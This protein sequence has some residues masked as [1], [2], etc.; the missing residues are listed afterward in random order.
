MEK[1]FSIILIALT[2]LLIS[3]CCSV[4]GAYDLGNHLT[5]L[6][7]DHTEDRVIVYCTTKNGCCDAGIPI[8]PSR[9]DSITLYVEKAEYNKL[10]IIVKGVNRED[11]NNF[12][13]IDKNFQV[14]FKLDDGGKLYDTIQNHVIGP[15]NLTEFKDKKQALNI[16][17]DFK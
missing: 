16:H 6:E 12:W 11:N 1:L 5:L 10:W 15:L 17:L 14:E 13:I 9:E 2:G 8:I 7:G 3:S 4:W